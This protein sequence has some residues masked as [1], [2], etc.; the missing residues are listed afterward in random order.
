MRR[1][2]TETAVR[3]KWRVKQKLKWRHKGVFHLRTARLWRDGKV[4]SGV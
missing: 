4:T 1:G 3:N 2:K